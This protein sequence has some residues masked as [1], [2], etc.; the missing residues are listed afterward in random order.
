MLRQQKIQQKTDYQ[1]FKQAVLQQDI[2]NVI[3]Y[4]KKD[5]VEKNIVVKGKSL[6]PLMIAVEYKN[7]SLATVLLKQ[8]ADPNCCYQQSP[9]SQPRPLSMHAVLTSSPDMLR[10]LHQQ[11]MD[12]NATQYQTNAL[13]TAISSANAPMV[14]VLL[15]LDIEI[16]QK[17]KHQ[18]HPLD[19]A[20]HLLKQCKR[21]EVT[22]KSV[23]RNIIEQ[24]ENKDA[25]QSAKFSLC[26]VS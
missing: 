19:D 5:Y 4:A 22:K 14:E 16:Y 8:G 9:F 23:L 20:K 25:R 1:N 11:G 15:E 12:I 10:L 6:P 26:C 2:D 7:L 24:I 13:H 18:T 21:R 17:N 3:K